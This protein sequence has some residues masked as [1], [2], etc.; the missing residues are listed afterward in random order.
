M[1][2]PLFSVLTF[3]LLLGLFAIG[4]WATTATAETDLPDTITYKFTHIGFP[5][6]PTQPGW[7]PD[8]PITQSP[9]LGHQPYYGALVNSTFSYPSRSFNFDVPKDGNYTIRFGGYLAP[10]GGK[11]E[12]YIDCEYYGTYSFFSYTGNFGPV[13]D[14]ADLFLGEGSHLVTFTI[15]AAGDGMGNGTNTYMFLHKL[16]VTNIDELVSSKTRSTIY[17]TQKVANA[18][19]NVSQYAWADEM[20]DNAVSLADSYLSMGHETI[21]KSVTSQ[22]LPRSYQ[23]NQFEGNLSPINGTQIQQYGNYPWIYDPVND[24]WKLTDPTSGYKFPTNDFGAYY[25]SGLDEHGFFDPL[26]ANRA[27]LVNTLYPDKGSTWGVDDG[28]GWVDP[29][30]GKRYTF[31]AYYNHW[32]IWT[33]TGG[34]KSLISGA[35]N[36]YRDAYLF[37]GDIK[38]ARA[39]AIL[40]DRV[41]DVYPGMDI[42]QHDHAIYLNSHGGAPSGKAVGSIW[43][44]GI[45]REYALAYD[46]FF[47]AMTDSTVLSF[48]ANKGAAYK[49]SH[50]DTATGIKRNI[51]DGLLRQIYPAVTRR[52]I[53]GNTGMHQSTLATAAVVLD[54]MPEIK[55]WL[56]FNYKAGGQTSTYPYQVTGGN[57]MPALVNQVDRDGAGNEAS[58]GYNRGWTSAYYTIANVLLGYDKY[59][60]ADLYPNVKFEQMFSYTYPLTMLGKYTPTIGDTGKTGDPGVQAYL[61]FA[62]K[63][64]EVYGDVQHAQMAYMLNG[65]SSVGLHG[66]IFSA[67]PEQVGLDIQNVINTN[68]V[69]NPSTTH[70]TGYGFSAL[71]QGSEIGSTQPPRGAWMYYGRNTGHGHKDTLNLGIHAFGMDLTPDLGYPEQASTNDA[72]SMEWVRNVISHNTVLVDRTKQATQVVSTPKHLDDSDFVELFDVEAPQVY[73]QT[74]L[75][76]R[77]TALVQVDDT[78]SYAVDF[79]R[80]KG[81]SEH[82]FSFHGAEGT[83]TV[84]GL[85]LTPQ[86]TGTY[87]GTGV[88]Y[89]QRPSG[90]SVA[91]GGYTGPGFHWLKNV[92][93]NTSPPASF[94]VDWSIKDTWNV[95][96]QGAHA[97]TDAHLRLTL[98]TQVNDV[99]LA[100]GVPPQNKPGNPT[101]L[102]YLIAHRSGTNLNSIFTSVIEPYKSTRFIQSIAPAVVRLNGTVIPATDVSV[103]AVKVVL[104]NGRTDYIVSAL[105]PSLTY[106]IDNIL[107]F[108]GAFGVYSEIG[109]SPER[110]YLQEGTKFGRIGTPLVTQTVAKL[111]GTIASFTQTLSPANSLTV[112]MNLNGVPAQDLLGKYIH[113]TNDGV[114]NA[115]YRIEAVTTTGTNQYALSIGQATP[116]RQYVNDNNFNQGFVYDVAVGQSF[117]IPIS[118]S[119]P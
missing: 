111:T 64:F 75:Y 79:F 59:S 3:T 15:V 16:M 2:N 81:G 35:L 96:G 63:A 46:A 118:K 77:T 86:A 83:A 26:R 85:T 57:I 62:V 54:T 71:R 55:E 90:D 33:R 80:V 65:N 34:Q 72:H 97:S 112:N 108:K 113:V 4:S 61:D 14:V 48:L 93:K 28:F 66:D 22:K 11:A 18:Q 24:P 30:S 38:Y 100:D 82:H 117:A 89:G 43:E 116:I 84:N 76:K 105:D 7:T 101:S 41:A 29:A 103:S 8:G 114:R 1:K 5:G 13:I 69:W 25:N 119:I 50:K 107:E 49:L 94:S 52:Q 56:D 20:R 99:A 109:G 47:P 95:F 36:A 104:A 74:S 9:S 32:A 58:P 31:I 27:L 37:D 115:V 39:G 42:T 6:Q 44:T 106:T 51:E 78:N 10:A 19:L 87:A 68:G 45:A 88:L 92:A 67:Q 12:I 21:W 40:L 98:L 23:T 17:T 110:G 70:S 73:S 91:G 60:T 102:R 53:F